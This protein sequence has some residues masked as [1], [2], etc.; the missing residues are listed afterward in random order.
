MAILTLNILWMKKGDATPHQ[1]LRE[2]SVSVPVASNHPGMTDKELDALLTLPM[3][4]GCDGY[5]NTTYTVRM[6]GLYNIFD[7]KC[8]LNFAIPDALRQ[9]E[10]TKRRRVEAAK[11]IKEWSEKYG[12]SRLQEQ[13]RQGFAGW[14]LYLHERL[15]KEFPGFELDN[16]GKTGDPL[17][18]PTLDQLKTARDVADRMVENDLVLSKQ[19]A[20]DLINIVPITFFDD[21]EDPHC[22]KHYIVYRDYRPGSEAFDAKTIRF[23]CEGCG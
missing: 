8:V 6:S 21:G 1:R 16:T 13:L 20:F 7:E 15:D 2:L 17:L 23:C 18:N 4:G 11:E 12:S 22:T 3:L 14:P 9:F 5:K 10:K 19:E